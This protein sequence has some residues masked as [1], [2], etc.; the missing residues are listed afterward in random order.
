MLVVSAVPATYL[1]VAS[2]SGPITRGV[3]ILALVF[4]IALV[5][6]SSASVSLTKQ[7][8]APQQNSGGD[9]D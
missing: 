4:T 3:I 9:R 2:P 1:A 8:Y 5:F 6:S 7:P